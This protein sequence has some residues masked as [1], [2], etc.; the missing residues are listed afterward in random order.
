MTAL[1]RYGTH[2]MN[3]M[4][5][6]DFPFDL[7]P[8]KLSLFFEGVLGGGRGCVDVVGGEAAVLPAQLLRLRARSQPQKR[9]RPTDY[10]GKNDLP[11]G[12][13]GYRERL[14]A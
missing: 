2:G 3:M 5:I 6:G 14:L 12:P 13:A 11:G 9:H 7:V 1:V 4:Q 8:R 10:E